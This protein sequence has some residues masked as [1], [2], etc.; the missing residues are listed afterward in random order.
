MLLRI[1]VCRGFGP[2][3][4]P[5]YARV[6]ARGAHGGFRAGVSVWPKEG[7]QYAT[8]TG[9][10]K[11]GLKKR[12]PKSEMECFHCKKK[13]HFKRECR[14]WLKLKKERAEKEAKE[15]KTAAAADVNSDESAKAEGKP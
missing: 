5:V 4:G 2:R 11:P 15:K 1:A 14:K 6:G 8:E 10:K 9:P 7:A 3:G 12:V 13:G